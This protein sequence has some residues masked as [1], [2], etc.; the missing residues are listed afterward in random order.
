MTLREHECFRELACEVRA[1]CAGRRVIEIVNTGN[2]G[3]S[4]IHAGQA[5]FMR[6][7]GISPQRVSIASLR[8]RNAFVLSGISRLFGGRAMVTGNGAYTK[9]YTRPQELKWVTGFFSQT[10]MM[11][12]SFPIFPSLD[13]SKTR[14]WRR[15]NLESAETIPAARFCHDMAFYLRPH[16]RNARHK[17]GVFFRKDVELGDFPLPETNRDISAEGT[18]RSDPEAFFDII[19]QYEVVF[20]NRLHVG[21]AAALLGRE[22][23]LFPSRTRKLQSVYEASLKPFYEN[24]HF[25][26]ESPVD[27]L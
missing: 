19:G 27:I 3:D 5:Q 14:I 13:L 1:F 22:V 11:P 17:R 25:H 6:D 2:W 16:P 20:T 7:L 24:V 4:V 18:H 12:S 21:I 10:L 15:D 26:T 8:R 9:W 23:H